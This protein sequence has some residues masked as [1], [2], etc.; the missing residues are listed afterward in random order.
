MSKIFSTCPLCEAHGLH[1]LGED[2]TQMMQCLNCGYTTSNNFIGT[3]ETNENFK[4]LVLKSLRV[5]IENKED[6]EI[7]SIY[8]LY[9]TTTYFSDC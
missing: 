2:E 5:D 6:K 3:M 4:K 9:I 1:I 8:D 7:E